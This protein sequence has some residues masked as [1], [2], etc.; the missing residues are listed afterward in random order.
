MD[1]SNLSLQELR[2]LENQLKSEIK[3]RENED[4]ARAREQI[5]A[6]A[7]SVGI[8]LKDLIGAK[9]GRGGAATATGA[10]RAAVAVRFRHPA[11]PSL[12]WTGRG[13]QPKWV[14]EWLAGGQSMDDLRV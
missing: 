7:H 5:L 4:M 13:R 11:D 8:P 12:Q 14:V 3:R 6:I 9:A 1:L 2:S 10:P